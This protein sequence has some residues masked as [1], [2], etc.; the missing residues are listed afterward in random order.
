MLKKNFTHCLLSIFTLKSLSEKSL[1][2][3]KLPWNRTLHKN[4]TKLNRELENAIKYST[5][6]YY[7]EKK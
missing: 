6:N 3:P 5:K 1:L 2:K 7:I 4:Q